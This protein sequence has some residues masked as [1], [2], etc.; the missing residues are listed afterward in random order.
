M[1]KRAIELHLKQK[2]EKW[3]ESIT[4]E[5]L[6]NKVRADLIVTGGSIASMLLQEK[7]NDYDIYISNMDTL[8]ALAEYYTFSVEW[9]QVLD[10]RKD[11]WEDINKWENA[12]INDIII[13]NIKEDQIKILFTDK[14][15]CKKIDIEEDKDYQVAFISPNAISLTGKI[16]IVLRFNGNADKIHSTFDFV[17]AT[18]YFTM[19]GGLVLRQ[20][21]LES[22]VTKQL[23]YKGSMYPITALIRIRKFVKRGW[24]ISAWQ[25]LKC[26][27]Q[28]SKLDLE[29]HKVLE[30][31]L[32]WVDVAFFS[33]LIE[34]LKEVNP[35]DITQEYIF[36][37]IDQIFEEEHEI[38]E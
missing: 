4:D 21:A 34:A 33:T 2:M 32:I 9:V 7:V 11:R 30:D 8:K 5:S 16:Q 15:W 18:N 10:G 36:E 22:I 20:E 38:E 3:L 19:E 35:E 37:L 28:V 26:A 12:W 13:G 6:R 29:D 24:K 1:N 25:I 14:W 31:Q 27:F 23:Q 17:H